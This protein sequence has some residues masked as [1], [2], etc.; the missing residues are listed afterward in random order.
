[1]RYIAN[2][3]W[4]KEYEELSIPEY[5][6]QITYRM[7]QPGCKP[8]VEGKECTHCGCKSPELFFD[9]SNDCSGMNWMPM[10]SAADWPEYKKGSAIEIDPDYLAQ[11]KKY[12]KIIKF[13]DS[14]S[15]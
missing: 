2:K 12:G 1:M 6:E 11:V 9:R 7:S 15:K 10:V 5:V 13:K 4:R 3:A 8:C 14:R